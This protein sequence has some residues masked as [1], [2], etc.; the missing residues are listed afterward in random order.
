MSA[1]IITFTDATSAT[2]ASQSFG[3]CN[4][5]STTSPITV[6][7]WNNKGGSTVVSDTAQTTLTTVTF[8]GLLTG[9]TV[10]NGQEVVNYSMLGVKCTSQGDTSF[11]QVG[12]PSG[13]AVTAPIGGVA[14]GTGVI[15]GNINGDAAIC[16]LQLVVPNN[17]TP[18]AAQWLGRVAYLYS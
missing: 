11:T 16:Q 12:A 4:A 6:Y 3:N 5:G 15:K 9:D 8:N 14:G 1:P 18:G 17:V 2:L 10:P 13:T 7:I